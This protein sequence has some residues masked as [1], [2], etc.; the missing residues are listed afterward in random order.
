MKYKNLGKSGLKVSQ[1]CLGSN[2][3]GGQVNEKV[4]IEIINTALDY[5]INI[6][7]TAD[8]YTRGRSEEVIGKAVKGRRN[9]VILATKVGLI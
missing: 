9:E 1:I 8:M 3:F 5:G 4:S 2:N 7:D 6:I